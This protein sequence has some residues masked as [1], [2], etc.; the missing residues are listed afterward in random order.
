MRNAD[1][2]TWL[3]RLVGGC[4]SLLAA[5]VAVYVAVRVLEAVWPVLVVIG[6]VLL[7]ASIGIAFVRAR[8]RG[9]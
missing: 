9:W 6:G 2:R 5:A 8:Y 1:P 4:L 7:V 3:D